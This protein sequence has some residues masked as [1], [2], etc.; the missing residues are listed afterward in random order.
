MVHAQMRQVLLAQGAY[1]LGTG[2]APFISRR[3][4]ERVTGPKS[5][6]W[7]VQ[8]TGVL[9]TTVG[10]G[11]VSAT[12]RRRETPEIVGIAAGC[13]AGLAA[14]DIVHVARGRI[15]L[16]YLADAAI[17]LTALGALR[18]SPSVIVGLD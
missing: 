6:W 10:A 8:T 3:L 14:I 1:Y 17:Q 9:V 15:S 13:A 16:V 5:D 12:L 11:I 18:R 4:F 7:L 2:V